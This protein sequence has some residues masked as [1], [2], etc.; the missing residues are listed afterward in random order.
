MPREPR[1]FVVIAALLLSVLYGAGALAQNWSRLKDDGVHDPKSPAV[2]DKQEPAEAL[3]PLFDA[4][5]DPDLGN[6]VRWA[7]LLEQGVIQPR[8][9]LWPDTKIRV[10]DLDIYLDVDG[11]MP[12]VRFPHKA[13]TMWLDC[14]NCHTSIFKDH[15]GE[16]PI[17]ML[18]ILEGEQCGVCHGAVA[19]PLTECLRCHSVRQVDFPA[20]AERLKL[21]RVGPKGKVAV[22]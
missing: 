10:L 22:Q 6:Q 5:P 14:S 1:R 16:T 17:S 2:K 13:H 8:T 3:K 11:S 15:A 7:K 4:A 20:I 18:T 12:V 21:R 19:F 9:N